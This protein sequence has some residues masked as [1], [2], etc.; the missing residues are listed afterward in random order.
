MPQWIHIT[1][2]WMAAVFGLLCVGLTI[3]RSIWC[4]PTGLMQVLLYVVV[5]FQAR[6]YSDL[7]L[8]VVYIGMQIYGWWAWLYGGRAGGP[9]RISRLSLP[10]TAAWGFVAISG[11]ATLGFVMNTWTD[12]TLPYWDAATTVLSLIAQYFLA[13]KVFENW[14]VWICVDVLCVII[15]SS[16]GLYVTTGLY[17]VFLLLAI[18]GLYTWSRASKAQ[19]APVVA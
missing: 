3:R 16:K 2:E 13:R 11:T 15:Y 14:I 19:L 8:H 12:A 4:W 5:F 10:A 6:L 1:I 7:L 9:L 18:T 17:M